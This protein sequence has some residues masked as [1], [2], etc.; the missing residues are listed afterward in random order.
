VFGG[1]IAVSDTKKRVMTKLSFLHVALFCPKKNYYSPVFMPFLKFIYF[2]IGES[3]FTI[4]FVM[5][6]WSVFKQVAVSK[7]ACSGVFMRL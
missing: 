2:N 4:I 3:P 5:N 1:Y 7:A 6:Q